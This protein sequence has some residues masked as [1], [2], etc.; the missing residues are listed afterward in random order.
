ML[1]TIDETE[2]DA[3]TVAINPASTESGAGTSGLANTFVDGVT[4]DTHTG[5][6]G[7]AEADSIVRLSVD[8]NSSGLTLTDSGNGN[9]AVPD[10]Q[11]SL[12]GTLDLND[13]NVF[14]L[15]GLRQITVTAED[16][17]GNVS[18]EGTLNIF[19]DTQGP[20]ITAVDVNE[21]GNPY[22]LFSPKPA[23]DGPTPPVSS[24][25]I[26]VQDFPLRDDEE[27]QFL[28]DAL[29]EPIAE[30]SAHYVLR[31]DHG[32]VIPIASVNFETV[33]EMGDPIANPNDGEAA[34]GRITLAFAEFLPDDR[35]TLTLSDSLVDPA[36][37]PLDG[38]NNASGPH[39][40]PVFPSGD[41]QAGGDFVA[42]FTIDSRPDIGVVGQGSISADINGNLD[43]DPNGLSSGDAV[44]QDLVFDFGIQTDAIFSGQFNTPSASDNDGFD[45]LGAYGLLGGRFRWLL[46]TD[47]DGVP[48]NGPASDPTAGAASLL[49]LNAVPF[50]GDFNPDHPGEEIG[51]FTGRTWYFDTDADNNIGPEGNINTGSGDTSIAGD[52]QGRPIVGDFYGDGLDDLGMHL[53]T[54]SA[55]RFYFDLTSA[56]DRTP[57][58]LDGSADDTIDFGFPGVR[59]KPFAA[60]FNLDGIDDIGLVVP[61]L[62]G[63]TPSGTSEWYFLISVSADQ[64]DGTVNALNHPFSPDP[65]GNDLFAQ[66]G[67]NLGLPLVGNFDPPVA[68]DVMAEAP[69]VSQP[70]ALVPPAAAAV[71]AVG[72]SDNSI[73]NVGAVTLNV[74]PTP[75]GVAI[76]GSGSIA[77]DIGDETSGGGESNGTHSE[78]PDGDDAS[79]ENGNDTVDEP[80]DGIEGTVT[81]E[82]DTLTTSL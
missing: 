63:D 67:S 55:N 32:G 22:D 69:T 65:L 29:W 18:D 59:E 31:G 47:N 41:G 48:D 38:G 66:F 19:V 37:N 34:F 15:D 72:S 20:R 3:P 40:D 14:P 17:A 61:N 50:S 82:L 11:W 53:A 68:R 24:L 43:F 70:A 7:T 60:D 36:G 73:I 35:Y 9:D 25:V 6:L 39:E 51:F 62:D 27:P 78:N 44:N 21:Q 30:D 57:R 33:D 81:V 64:M 75:V 12:V 26:S 54:Q 58:V 5:F 28:Y 10:G 76:E 23:T 56:A 13:P 46:D 71:V 16:R 74:V 45:R 42:R 1:V 8:G 79:S 4:R 80:V 77:A 52:M 49:Q 2:P